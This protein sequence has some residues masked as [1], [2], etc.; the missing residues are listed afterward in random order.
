VIVA[1]FLAVVIESGRS[2]RAFYRAAHFLP[3]MATLASMSIAWE[4]MLHP[5]IGM[6]NQVL[7]SIGLT[8]ANWLN[9]PAT[10]LPVLIVI[11]IWQYLGFAMVMFLAGLKAI[12]NVLY[13]AGE[14]DGV[15]GGFNRFRTITLPMLGPIMMLVL[16]VVALHAFKT[17]DTVLILTKGGPGNRSE[18]LMHTLYTESFIY[19]R[20]GYGAAMT[21]VFLI[22]VLVLTLVQARTLDKRVH[23]S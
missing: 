9:D 15:E 19:F 1:L 12:P 3:V 21:V 7:G 5:T 18:L 17:F 10:V 16:I 6:V 8:G 2:F 13:D 11:G 22:I 4:A 14:I 20:T 23:Y